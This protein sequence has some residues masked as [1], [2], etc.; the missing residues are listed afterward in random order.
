MQPDRESRAGYTGRGLGFAPPSFLDLV[1]IF[2]GVRSLLQRWLDVSPHGDY[3]TCTAIV[4]F[5]LGREQ[6][7]FHESGRSIEPGVVED[8]NWI[9]K[10]SQVK[11]DW[12]I[13]II[14]S[15]VQTDWLLETLQKAARLDHPAAPSI[16]GASAILPLALIGGR[17]AGSTEVVVV[18]PLYLGS[19]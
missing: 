14:R 16:T 4:K 9:I 13:I 5:I 2:L 11:L 19:S 7:P 1:F 6:R 3:L 17:L 8:T 15:T 10:S 12:I 18:P